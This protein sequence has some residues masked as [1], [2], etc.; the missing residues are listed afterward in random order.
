MKTAPL[1]SIGDI[2]GRRTPLENHEVYVGRSNARRGLKGS[3]LANP[4]ILKDESDRSLVLARYRVWLDE[5]ILARASEVTDEMDR[6]RAT[7]NR[8]GE[9]V[10]LCWCAPKGCHAEAIAEALRKGQP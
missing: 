6:L 7:A 1:V 3:P 10:L 2:R 4:F 8:H 9:L 5:R